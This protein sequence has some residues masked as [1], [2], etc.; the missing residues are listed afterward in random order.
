MHQRPRPS[1][2]SA[3]PSGPSRPLLTET[4]PRTSLD[5]DS[6]MARENIARRDSNAVDPRSLDSTP[7][8]D[9]INKLN[10]IIQNYHTKAALILL[11]GR[12][13]LRPIYKEGSKR[14]NKWFNVEIDETD[15]LREDLSPWRT[16]NATDKRPMPLVVETYLDTSQLTNFQDLVIIDDYGKRWDVLEALSSLPGG[17]EKRKGAT[18]DVLL[19]RWHISLGSPTSSLPTD[20]GGVLPNLY[21]KSI[22]LFRSLFAYSKLLPAWKFAKRQSKLPTSPVLRLKHRIFQSDEP[23]ITNEVDNLTVPLHDGDKKVV[24]DYSFGI[25]DSP[26]GPFS[27]RVIYRTNCEFRVDDS[28]T[29]LSSRFMGVDDDLFRP[30][31]PSEHTTTTAA[32]EVGSLPL[33]SRRI[34]QPDLSQAYGSMSTFHHADPG[35]R[36]SPISALR[37]ARQLG[38][39]S[40]S[41]PVHPPPSPRH[42]GY[43]SR[44]ASLSGD[45]SQRR[46]SISYNPFKAPPLSASPSLNS[47]ARSPSIRGESSSFQPPVN[48]GTPAVGTISS[49]TPSDQVLSLR[50]FPS[51]TSASPKLAPSSK[52]TSSFSHRRGR[53]STGGGSKTEEDNQS[54]GKASLSSSV[55]QPSSALLT[56]NAEGSYGSMHHADEDNISD[57]L[58]LLDQQKDLLSPV[59]SVAWDPSGKRTTAALSRFQKMRDTNT[60]LSDSLSSSL[61]LNRSSAS[62]SKHLH[63]APPLVAGT[64]VSTA[65]SSPGKAISPHTPHTPAVP[66]RLSSGSVAEYSNEATTTSRRPRLAHEP[67]ESPLEETNDESLLDPAQ[68]AGAIDIPRSP[69]GFIPSYRRCSSAAQR[70]TS[71]GIDEDVGDYIPFATRSISL[72]AQNRSPPNIDELLHQP[73]AENQI[74][75][76]ST[77]LQQPNQL[78]E[79]NA[80][81]RKE[82]PQPVSSPYQPRFA[83][84]RGRGSFGISNSHS[85]TSSSV[86][87]GI[88]LHLT[89]RDRDTGNGS[90][91]N[92][93][94][95]TAADARRGSMRRFSFNRHPNSPWNACDEDEPLLFTMSDFG[96]SRRSLEEPQRGSPGAGDT[97]DSS[98]SASV[99]A[100]ARPTD[101]TSRNSR[102]RGGGSTGGNPCSLYPWD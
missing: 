53:L 18:N 95:S 72:G 59:N 42:G 24:E 45:G 102:G 48:K 64:S 8:Q 12:A 47:Q 98:A 94:I 66:S 11:Q 62:S 40:P 50:P 16:C 88:P 39:G 7:G 52:Y 14:V 22:V 9:Q 32:Q 86:G 41:P 75:T 44:I 37:A 56:D 79:P 15:V 1:T 101:P 74:P 49:R 78:V 51:S 80:S 25:I 3:N 65:S 5:Q 34:Q 6:T 82:S 28:E 93:G 61:M 20:L 63:N 10:Q 4:N 70:R 97:N 33:K 76:Q 35:A 100:N 73:S 84:H 81:S 90:G 67:H 87:R 30:S 29:L 43:S 99:T 57:F 38:G 96:V 83:H 68:A 89:D 17:P 27:I 46:P 60:A 92:S 21:K 71:S 19:E 2:G 54:S 77:D 13:E 58:K 31:L 91:S 23:P 26:A 85:S 36:G 69:H 55:A